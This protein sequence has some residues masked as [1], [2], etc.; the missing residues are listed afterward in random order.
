MGVWHMAVCAFFSGDFTA[1]TYGF[2]LSHS[3]AAHAWRPPYA[4]ESRVRW[5]LPYSHMRLH[6]TLT[7]AEAMVGV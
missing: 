6:M 4:R 2:T 3:T 5:G 7:M 1:V